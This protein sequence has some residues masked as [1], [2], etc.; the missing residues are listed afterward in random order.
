MNAYPTA[1]DPRYK[2]LLIVVYYGSWPP[3]FPAYLESCRTNETIDWLFITDCANPPSAPSN[4]K[5]TASTRENLIEMVTKRLAIDVVIPSNRKLCDIRP[6]YGVIFDNHI[7]GYDFWGFCDVDVI[8][9]NIRHFYTDEIL[10]KYDAISARKS[11]LSGHFT[12]LRNCNKIN[13]AFWDYPSLVKILV[14]PAYC[15]FDEQGFSDHLASRPSISILWDLF[16]VNFARFVDDRPSI[17]SWMDRYRWKNGRLYSVSEGS[18]EIMYLHFMN[19]KDSLAWCDLSYGEHVEEFDIS[20]CSI[21][22]DGGSAPLNYRLTSRIK[23]IKNPRYYALGL[24]RRILKLVSK[25]K[26]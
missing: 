1:N 3:W 18:T 23:T 25:N 20:Y 11:R 19:W 6:I 21:T 4:V 17:L 14:N 12:L 26:H 2:I 5:F 13:L 8:W 10:A 15:W 7:Q 24:Y 16:R 22:K 9:G